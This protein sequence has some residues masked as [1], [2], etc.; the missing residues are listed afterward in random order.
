MRRLLFLLAFIP[1]TAHAWVIQHR[2]TVVAGSSCGSALIAS[3]TFTESGT[4]NIALNAHTKTTGGTWVTGGGALGLNDL[5]LDR[6]NDLVL[7]TASATNGA[8]GVID[9]TVSCYN[10]NVQMTARTGGTGSNRIGPM[11]RFDIATGNG[12]WLRITG[13]GSV[14]LYELIAN[15]ADVQLCTD[16]VATLLGSFATSTNYTLLLEMNGTTL[17]A[18]INSTQLCSVTNS[19]YST[20]KPG[21]KITNTSPRGD[22]FSATFLP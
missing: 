2:Q 17:T 20:G 6:T 1:C 11:G 12:Y 8:G 10:Y 19:T 15:S 3:D 16:S 13:G 22:N 4:G 14:E 7:S 21:V 5:S 9:D 18:S